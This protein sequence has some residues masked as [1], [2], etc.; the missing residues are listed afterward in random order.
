ML[1][2]PVQDYN[3]M[4][5]TA[6][7]DAKPSTAAARIEAGLQVAG[8][9]QRPSTYCCMARRFVCNQHTSH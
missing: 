1:N 3:A 7:V 9:A 6:L 8:N 2:R 5:S 4:A